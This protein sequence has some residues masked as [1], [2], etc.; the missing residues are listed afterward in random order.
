MKNL[1]DLTQYNSYFS[2]SLLNLVIVLI[3]S[4]ILY[5]IRIGLLIAVSID[6]FVESLLVSPLCFPLVVGLFSPDLFDSLVNLVVVLDE[7]LVSRLQ[8]SDVSNFVVYFN[9]LIFQLHKLQ[10]LWAIR[11]RVKIII[12][13]WVFIFLNYLISFHLVFAIGL[14][15]R[16][17][18]LKFDAHFL[19]SNL[20]LPEIQPIN[21]VL[22]AFW[23]VS[24][25]IIDKSMINVYFFRAF[26]PLN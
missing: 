17:L 6:D 8:L 21:N 18:S 12:F 25:L 16:F 7:L 2:I 3:C 15:L 4:S 13:F 26:L 5:G 22:C 1:V 24:L 19:H 23:V 14:L 11:A 10:G 20:L 9:K